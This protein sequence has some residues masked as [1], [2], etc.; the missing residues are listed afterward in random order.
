MYQMRSDFKHLT[1]ATLSNKSFG[2]T[3]NVYLILQEEEENPLIVNDI[4][5][6]EIYYEAIK[7]FT[8]GHKTFSRPDLCAYFSDLLKC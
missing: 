6:M 3:M 5:C 1:C 2:T 8:H 4:L 7:Y